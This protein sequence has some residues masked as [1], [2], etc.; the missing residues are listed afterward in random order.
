[1]DDL[2]AEQH[3]CVAAWQLVEARVHH[4]AVQDR[5][6]RAGL[7]PVPGVEGV[8]T[9]VRGPLTDVQR[10]RAATL[11]APGTALTR[12]SAALHWGIED[13]R[14]TD[15]QFVLVVRRGTAGPRRLGAVL[16]CTTPDLDVIDHLGVPVTPPPRTVCDLAGQRTEDELRRMVLEVLRLRLCDREALVVEVERV[17]RR[18]GMPRLRR[19][20]RSVAGLPVAGNASNAESEALVRLR[21]AGREGFETNVWVE[22]FEADLVDR[23]AREIIE[24]D[25]AQFHLDPVRDARKDAAWRAAGWT[26]TR[27]PASE[28]YDPEARW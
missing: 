27:R 20:L 10:R 3:E 6:R 5:L 28:V 26:V 24:V 25:G 23:G 1:M 4:R 21:A 15:A 2:L 22:G 12:V 17:P 8:W 16:V 7:R 11:T 14:R 19:V 9:S 13:G 18:P